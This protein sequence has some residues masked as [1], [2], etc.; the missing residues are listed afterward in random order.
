M[1]N[2]IRYAYHMSWIEKS[3][4]KGDT[5]NQEHYKHEEKLKKILHGKKNES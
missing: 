5:T 4:K 3:I 1:I 2:K